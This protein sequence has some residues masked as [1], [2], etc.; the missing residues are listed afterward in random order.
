MGSLMP[1]RRDQVSD[2]FGFSLFLHSSTSQGGTLMNNISH[3]TLIFSLNLFG[4]LW[5]IC[6]AIL[7]GVARG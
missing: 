4:G 1:Y 6:S 5:T 7:I 2:R 3:K